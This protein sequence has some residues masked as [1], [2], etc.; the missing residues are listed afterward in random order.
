MEIK[1]GIPTLCAASVDEWRQWLENNGQTK[2]AVWLIVYHKKSKVASVHWHD[3]I[4]NA[5]CYGWVDS[6]AAGRDKE[7]CFLKFTPRSPKSKW[8]KRNKERALKMT[9]KGLMT[10][11]GQKLI[12]IAKETGKWDGG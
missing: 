12:D 1:E 7:S 8:G 3:A 11:H 2:Q 10:K 9:E 5:L 4:E 6:K